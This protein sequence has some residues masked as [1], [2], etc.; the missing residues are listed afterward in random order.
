MSS[1]EEFARVGAQARGDRPGEL[2]AEV[3][4]GEA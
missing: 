3:K 4:R 1:R 2:L